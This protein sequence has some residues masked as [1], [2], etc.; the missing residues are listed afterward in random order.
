ML[1]R[2]I[3][4][5]CAVYLAQPEE[6]TAD[7]SVPAEIAKVLRRHK[8]PVVLLVDERAVVYRVG[9][10][11]VSQSIDNCATPAGAKQRDE[12]RPLP[13][14]VDTCV[15][16]YIQKNRVNETRSVQQERIL[17]GKL[18]ALYELVR[19]INLSLREACSADHTCPVS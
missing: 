11:V 7:V 12:R 10:V 2:H 1:T 3:P 8:R 13:R 16:L 19:Q 14:Q 15:V 5:R 4:G 18:G 9:N 17:R 6:E